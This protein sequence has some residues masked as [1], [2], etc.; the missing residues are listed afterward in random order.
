MA[1]VTSLND[2]TPETIDT[3]KDS[4]VEMEYQY[5]RPGGASLDLTGYPFKVV[6]AGLV[7]IKDSNDNVKPLP[8]N[9]EGTAYEALPANHTYEGIVRASKASA[10]PM[11]G[12]TWK[13]TIN[14]K[15][16]PLPIPQAVK[17]HFKGDIMFSYDR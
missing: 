3:E 14:E 8:V 2:L 6:P 9:T 17:D 13:G 7:L 16:C 4:I 10:L 15:V 11:V 5:G 1:A 12:I